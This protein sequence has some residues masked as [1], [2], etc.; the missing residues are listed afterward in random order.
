MAPLLS[1]WKIHK[2]NTFVKETIRPTRIRHHDPSGSAR[3]PLAD[4]GV[5]DTA[6]GVSMTGTFF[7]CLIAAP[8]FAI[9]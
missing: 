1:G 7:C 6:C 4:F 2:G 3:R 8:T 9:F 5:P